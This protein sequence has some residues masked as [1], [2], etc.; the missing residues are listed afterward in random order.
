M[1]LSRVILTSAIVITLGIA[2]C[3][4]TNTT[5]TANST[6][7]TEQ[8][9]SQEKANPTSSEINTGVTKMLGVTADLKAAITAGDEAKVKTVGPELEDNWKPFE[10]KVKEKY[11]DIYKKIEAALDPTI[12]GAKAS[13]LDKQVLG[14]LTGDLTDALNELAAKEK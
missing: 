11:P 8:K 2:G 1:N 14:K 6:N 12:A 3:G 9:A 5:S 4:T 10:D 7:Q 13:P